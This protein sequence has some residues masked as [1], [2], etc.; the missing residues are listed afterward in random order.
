MTEPCVCEWGRSRGVECARLCW[1][2][3]DHHSP[4]CSCPKVTPTALLPCKGLGLPWRMVGVP[5]PHLAACHA[6]A[7]PNLRR[8]GSGIA[9]VPALTAGERCILGFLAASCVMDY[10]EVRN[11]FSPSMARWLTPGS[12]SPTCHPCPLR[13]SHS[14]QEPIVFQE[15]RLQGARDHPCSDRTGPLLSCLGATT[16]SALTVCA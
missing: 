3:S 13:H 12:C 4:R 16:G 15:T 9:G 10:G 14:P 1:A 7:A 8:P 11:A 5:Q 2:Y 6:A